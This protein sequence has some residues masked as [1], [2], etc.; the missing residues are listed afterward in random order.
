MISSLNKELT[1]HYIIR[2]HFAAITQHQPEIL[3]NLPVDFEEQR[4]RRILHRFHDADIIFNGERGQDY[5][6][7]IRLG[8]IS[9]DLLGFHQ[10][11]VHKRMMVYFEQTVA[12]SN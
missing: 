4:S 12:Y 11:F 8:I 10:S 6:V 9:E 3:F 7:R 1:R 5:T 2:I